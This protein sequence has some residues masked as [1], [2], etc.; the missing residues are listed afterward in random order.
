MFRPLG[1]LTALF[2][3]EFEVLNIIGVQNI[4]DPSTVEELV[5]KNDWQRKG[6]GIFLLQ[7]L[8]TYYYAWNNSH[9]SPVVFQ[10][11]RNN[12]VAIPFYQKIKCDEILATKRGNGRNPILS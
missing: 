7:L 5:L 12:T 1:A 8:I 4:L 2:Q 10:V 11:D 9:L 3:S 6:T